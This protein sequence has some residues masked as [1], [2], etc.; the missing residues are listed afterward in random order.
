[1]PNGAEDQNPLLI[2]QYIIYFSVL[3]P[4]DHLPLLSTNTNDYFSTV[5]LDVDQQLHSQQI[6]LWLTTE[7]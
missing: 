2:L 1:V 7:Y 3:L 4:I 6:L 5:Q